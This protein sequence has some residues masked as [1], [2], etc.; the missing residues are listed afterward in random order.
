MEEILLK[1]K[2]FITHLVLYNGTKLLLA[3]AI[4]IV[5]WKLIK[6]LGRLL[7]NIFI[8]K[9]VDKSLQDF[10]LSLTAIL[11][12][13]LLILTVMNMVGIEIT[14]F[15]AI[16]GAAGLAVGM[17]LQGTLQNFAGGIIILIL[18]PFKVGDFIEQGPFSG[19]V[20]KIQIF[21]TVLCTSDN[22]III[23]PN[24]QLATNPITNYTR[25]QIRRV[26]I[27]CGIAYGESVNRA[28]ETMLSIAAA[29]PEILT[30]PE[31]PAVLVV[32]LSDS[33]VNLQLRVWVKTEDYWNV[34]FALN[35][36]VYDKFTE[37]GIEIP[38]NQLQVH[39]TQKQA[40]SGK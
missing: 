25:S 35:Q 11:L 27:P 38:F 13:I 30:E 39:L 19:E 2:E 20:K 34:H 37:A 10:L 1:A 33:S 36:A 15:I 4:L 32:A 7:R 23:L 40:V 16:L 14:S 12:K 17:A 31:A 28:R 26:D 18:K 22:K 9:E 5:G 3:L 29:Y 24:T 8:R 6:F 21:N